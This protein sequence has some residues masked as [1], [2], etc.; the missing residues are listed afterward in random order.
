MPKISSYD[1]LESSQLLGTDNFLIQRTGANKIVALATLTD[2]LSSQIGS[3]SGDESGT[4]T[5]TEYLTHT[6]SGSLSPTAPLV[7]V[8]AM[9]DVTLP[10]INDTPRIVA[11]VADAALT[12]TCAGSDRFY[13]GSISS[14]P[15]SHSLSANA[16]L[17][18]ASANE[19]MN[20]WFPIAHITDVGT[21]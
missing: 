17:V 13:F 14:G 5:V 6:S 15:T 9:A 18:I 21:L 11:I 16:V 1:A 7:L 20:L 3:M 19:S 10:A 2:Y 12:V 4:A 8:I